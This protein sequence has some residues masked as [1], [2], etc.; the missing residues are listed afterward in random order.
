M[1]VSGILGFLPRLKRRASCLNRCNYTVTAP[2]IQTNISVT[3]E[4]ITVVDPQADFST[5]T[6]TV[7]NS[8]VVQILIEL[9]KADTATVNLGSRDIGCLANV[10]VED[11]DGNGEVVLEWDTHQA[12]G[13]ATVSDDFSVAGSAD[14]IRSTEIDPGAQPDDSV[15]TGTHD[16]DVRA[17][18]DAEAESQRSADVVVEDYSTDGTNSW[19]ASSTATPTEE[20]TEEPTDGPTGGLTGEPSKVLTGEPTEE[21][22]ETPTEKPTEEPPTTEQLTVNDQSTDAPTTTEEPIPGFGISVS[23]VALV[24]VALLPLR[25]QH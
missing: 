20:P 16:L 3:I 12:G 24:A 5:N 13:T 25:R 14:R 15:D 1:V 22:T 23:L 7:E 6:L 21:S 2:D 18:T 9:H 17:G 8:D 4:A 11:G 10:T 19:S